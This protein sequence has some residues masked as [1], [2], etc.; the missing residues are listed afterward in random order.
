MLAPTRQTEWSHPARCQ[1]SDNRSLSANG[2]A[3]TLAEHA[4]GGPI[5]AIVASSLRRVVRMAALVADRFGAVLRCWNLDPRSMRLCDGQTRIEAHGH[6][7][8]PLADFAELSA[9]IASLFDGASGP[10]H[11]APIRACRLKTTAFRRTLVTP[12][13]I[14]RLPLG[15]GCNTF[16]SLRKIL[17]VS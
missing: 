4:S 11:R 16:P 15:T 12:D 6:R 1:A 8:K 3:N 2:R 17:E 7:F 9:G 10:I 5:D 14:S 13:S